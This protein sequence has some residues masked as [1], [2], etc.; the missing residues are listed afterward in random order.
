MKWLLVGV[1]VLCN[2]CADLLSTAGMRRHGKVAHLNP[3]GVSR[4]LKAL[5][6]NWYV[7]AGVVANA[8]GF[9]TL[10]SLLSIADVSFAVPATAASFVLETGLARLILKEDVHWQRWLGAIAIAFG[11]GLLALP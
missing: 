6:R 3:R 2:S 10:M 4:L 7:L 9:F 11:V 8:A 1:I 5:A